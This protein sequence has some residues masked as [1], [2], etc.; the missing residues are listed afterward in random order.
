MPTNSPGRSS[1]GARQDDAP[2][3]KES[4]IPA[5]RDHD[6]VDID[7]GEASVDVAVPDDRDPLDPLDGES[8]FCRVRFRHRLGE[9]DLVRAGVRGDQGI[10]VG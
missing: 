5:C 4:D 3:I 10:R 9:P 7:H 2:V 1:Q 6:V 8:A